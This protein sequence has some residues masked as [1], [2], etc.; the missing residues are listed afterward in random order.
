MEKLPAKSVGTMPRSLK[1]DVSFRS[2][3]WMIM[4]KLNPPL[5][6]VD[7]HPFDH[8]VSAVEELIGSLNGAG[9][10]SYSQIRECS[11]IVRESCGALL[12]VRH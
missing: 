1:R 5:T 10:G 8:G 2:Q 11:L 6:T 12:G 9:Q 7:L 4:M 3:P